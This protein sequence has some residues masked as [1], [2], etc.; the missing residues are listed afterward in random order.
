MLGFLLKSPFTRGVS[1]HLRGDGAIEPG[2]IV[3]WNASPGRLCS[4][5]QKFLFPTPGESPA[6][7][8]QKLFCR[9]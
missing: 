1:L 9:L 8:C 5:K 4:L 6:K 2:D 3:I 7:G